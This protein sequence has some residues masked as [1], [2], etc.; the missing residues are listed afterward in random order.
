MTYPATRTFTSQR[1]AFLFCMETTSAIKSMTTNI[2][3][4]TT[5]HS[6][7]QASCNAQSFSRTTI[8]IISSAGSKLSESHSSS[9]MGTLTI[10]RQLLCQ[11]RDGILMYARN[12]M[13]FLAWRQIIWYDHS[14]KTKQIATFNKTLTL[15]RTYCGLEITVTTT[16]TTKVFAYYLL[17]WNDLKMFWNTLV[18][19]LTVRS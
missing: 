19:K 13:K 14:K 4:G 1:A 11:I 16:V 17:W 2:D 3:L 9:S 8:N 5:I 18:R 7:R 10:F 15:W 6:V 12:G